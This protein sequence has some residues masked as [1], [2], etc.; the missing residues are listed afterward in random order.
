MTN[1]FIQRCL[2]RSSAPAASLS[3]QIK[4]HSLINLGSNRVFA[5]QRAL[6]DKR[7]QDRPSKTLLKN[8]QKN[9][10]TKS[11]TDF[12]FTLGPRMGGLFYFQFLMRFF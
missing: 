9:I 11:K 7:F 2:P 6:S 5:H 1:A 12:V 10:K 4:S 3:S 8:Y